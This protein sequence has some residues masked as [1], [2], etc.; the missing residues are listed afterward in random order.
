MVKVKTDKKVVKVKIDSQALIIGLL[1]V[2]ITVLTVNQFFI[3]NITATLTKG[4]VIGEVRQTEQGTGSA[5]IQTIMDEVVPK[6][7]P[8]YGGMAQVSFDNVDSSLQTLVGYHMSIQLDGEDLQRYIKIG[9]TR[10]TACEFCCGIGERGFAN[11]DGNIL[12]GC[13]HN[14]AFSGLTKWLIKNTDYNDEQIVEAIKDWKG[15]FFPGPMVS[16]ELA[17]RGINPESV[18]LPAI[19]GGC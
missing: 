9:T 15:V 16:K 13:S 18:G 19:Q 17:R 3:S 12:C 14:I 7:T 5:S 1:I 2:V 11:S 10:E 4:F 8:E 6:G